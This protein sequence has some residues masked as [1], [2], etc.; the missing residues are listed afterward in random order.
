MP[1][2]GAVERAVRPAIAEIA[3]LDGI[4]PVITEARR[5]GRAGREGHQRQRERQRST[6]RE[7][8]A[9]EARRAEYA[10]DGMEQSQCSDLLWLCAAFPDSPEPEGRRLLTPCEF[11]RPRPRAPDASYAG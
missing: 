5:L 11:L 1:A 3:V 10:C 2:R 4:S 7:A 6:E 9:R 8:G